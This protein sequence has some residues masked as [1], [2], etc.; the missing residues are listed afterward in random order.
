MKKNRSIA[1]LLALLSFTSSLVAQKPS[2]N[3]AEFGAKGDGKTLNTR[4]LQAVIDSC[5][6]RGGGAIVI[7]A[8][9]FLT[10]TLTLKSNLRIHIEAG[11]ELLASPNLQDYNSAHRHLL[12]GKAIQN[13]SISGKGSINGNG[14]AFFDNNFNALDRPVPFI[15]L[16]DAEDISIKDIKIENS[17]AHTLVLSGC[18]RAVIDG[19]TILNDMRSPNTDGIDITSSSNVM[20]SN[21]FISTGDDAICLKT[22]HSESDK[23]DEIALPTL[24][25]SN[26]P[27]EN[28]TVTNCI[29]ESDD[30]ALKL[31]TGSGTVIGYCSFNNIII[32]NARFGIAL[33][34]KD[35][36]VYEDLH[37]SNIQ[38][39]TSSRHATEYPI[40]IDVEKR[41][42]SGKYGTVQ[43][44]T[45]KGITMHTRGNCLIAGQKDSPLKNFS[46][47]DLT[48]IVQ[49]AVDVA[50]FKKPRGNKRLGEIIGSSDFAATPS[51]I[52]I[53]HA[54]HFTLKNIEV[55]VN[56]NSNPRHAISFHNAHT[57]ALTDFKYR[58][59]KALATVLLDNSADI[60]L[61]R[62]ISSTSPFLEVKGDFQ[63]DLLLFENRVRNPRSAF[64]FPKPRSRYNVVE[65][66]TIELK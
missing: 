66:N 38:I 54:E 65:R 12:Y 36:G 3:V 49:E 5:E 41:E 64:Q 57:V 16:E 29:I 37:F 50:R 58:A 30:G 13:F 32:R 9:K 35:G 10:G 28:V 7:P 55:I 18:N 11:G 21:C 47:E 39:Q 46:F 53:G 25:N 8:G 6:K 23:G 20:I 27:T 40:F 22:Y 1:L 17:P 42:N 60:T 34:M 2:L 31:G 24:R 4:A 59:S 33:F 44:V 56:G 43:F 61:A 15:V 48:L 19:I 62:N 45:F 26:K 63:G 51:H 52:T 14:T